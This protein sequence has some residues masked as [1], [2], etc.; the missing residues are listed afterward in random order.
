MAYPT[1]KKPDHKKIAGPRKDGKLRILVAI[2]GFPPTHYAGAERA[3]ERIVRW[4]AVRGHHVEVF[5]VERADD[6]DVRI[7]SSEQDGT[8]VHRLFYDVKSGASPFHNTYQHPH[9]AEAF[10]NVVAGGAFDLVHMISGYLLGGQ[11]VHIAHEF[12]LPV[13]ITLTEYWFMCARL[14]LLHYDGAMCI[15]PETD[16]KCVR[17]LMEDK[18]R[19]RLPAQAAPK[20]MDRLWAAA[21][22]TSFADARREEVAFRGRAL[23][24]ALEAA[25]LVICPSRFIINKFAEFGFD[26][27]RFVFVR[28]GLDAGPAKTAM[29][30][31]RPDG[32]LRLGYIGQIKPHKGVDL[33]VEAVTALVDAGYEMSLE[34]WGAPTDAPRYFAQLE[35]RTARYP[36]IQWM[37][38]YD[39]ARVWDVLARFDALVVPSRWYE[40][41]PTVVL[42]AQKMKVP[43]VATDL[44]GM[45]ELVEHGKSGLL[46][47]LNNVRDLCRQLE[48]LLCEPGLLAQLREGAPYVKTAG[49]E[50]GEIFDHYMALLQQRTAGLEAKGQK[51]Q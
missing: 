42:E 26:T 5:A 11:V 4:L 41:C 39:G 9:V 23:R 13:V 38:R 19:Y 25:D 17:C 10:R 47:E 7:E 24:Q 14:N 3:G 44:G 27:R 50:V 32:K 12:G 28:H 16:Q 1:Q 33:A 46:F 8:L 30:E 51:E 21:F 18:R 2:H 43:V 37:G 29:E 45:A 49:E 6:P 31:A 20:L 34:L 35:R 48:R 15:G 22:R 36:S 40:N